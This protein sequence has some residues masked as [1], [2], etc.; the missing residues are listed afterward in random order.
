MDCRTPD[1]IKTVARRDQSSGQAPL[2][3]GSPRHRIAPWY[4]A[5]LILGLL[6]SGMLPFLLPLVV[7]GLSHQLGTVAYVTGAY[8][9]GLLPAPIFGVLAERRHLYRPVFFSAFIL[10]SLSFVTF[11]LVTGLTPWFLV[12]LLI[13]ASAGAA[14][15]VATLF[16]VDFEP[17]CEWEPRIGWL[18]TFNG[19]GQLA[20]LL[21]AAGFA[22]GAFVA[23]FALAGGLALVAVMVG[24]IGLPPDGRKRFGRNPIQHLPVQPL[25]APALLNPAFS[26]LLQHSHHL[27]W[28]AARGLPLRPRGA[29]GRFLLSWA[30]FNFGVAA[31]FAYYPLI[32]QQSYGIPPAVTALAYAVAACIGIFLF[33]AASR[34]AVRYGARL[35]FLSGLMVRALGFL[36]LGVPYAVAIPCTAQIALLGFL[37]A[38][39]AWPVLSVSG[40]T[41]AARLT[42]VGEGAAIGLLGTSAA[43]PTMLG[44]FA[45]G[46]LV[47]RFGYGVVPPLAI[48]GLAGAALL[49]LPGENRVAQ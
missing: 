8:N 1:T 17:K 25:L 22:H 27:Q 29:F 39:L 19:V 26:N 36:L 11:P 45:S 14:A 47:H 49:M 10:L 30:A 40:T 46:P 34:L 5:Y 44:T 21:L 37:L 43:L 12:A 7:A 15:T 9:L 35:V 4:L 24:G 33:M 20:G 16:I 28:A 41:L 3:A 13:G 18:Q 2:S 23:G 42:P 6:T 38:M 48:I 31:F 32:M